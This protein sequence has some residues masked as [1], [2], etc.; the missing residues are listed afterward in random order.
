[1]KQPT[2]AIYVND[3]WDGQHDKYWS[4]AYQLNEVWY[5]FENDKNVLEYEGDEI[6]QTV[7]LK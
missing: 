2:H 6:L 5:H 3:N 4:F 7:I 1:M